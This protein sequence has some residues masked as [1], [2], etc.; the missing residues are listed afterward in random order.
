M[1]GET[2]LQKVTLPDIISFSRAVLRNWKPTSIHF[3]IAPLSHR[4]SPTGRPSRSKRAWCQGAVQSEWFSLKLLPSRCPAPGW[5][6]W[7]RCSAARRSPWPLTLPVRLCCGRFLPSLFNSDGA[8]PG[9]GEDG[10][11][12][13][14]L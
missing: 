14:A 3:C 13:L 8:A 11:A 6:S 2:T 12:A 1:N 5:A 7:L 4:L 9:R 10:G